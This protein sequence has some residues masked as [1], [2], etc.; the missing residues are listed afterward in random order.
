[1]AKITVPTPNTTITS[2]WGKSVA[3]AINL[4][5]FMFGGYASV[6]TD[7]NGYFNITFPGGPL[8][9]TPAWAI[10]QKHGN[11]VINQNTNATV[12]GITATLLAGQ[13]YNFA[14]PPTAIAGQAMTFSYLVGLVRT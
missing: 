1:V 3:D 5:P 2:V 11:S 12:L 10:L 14:A 8:P 13:A 9:F 7:A 4:V 6:T